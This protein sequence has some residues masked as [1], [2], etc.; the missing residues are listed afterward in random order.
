MT[1]E[2]ASHR[3]DEL[4]LP[5]N[6]RPLGENAC[7][8]HSVFHRL[9]MHLAPRSPSSL[10]SVRA[11][12]GAAVFSAT[13]P[14]TAPGCPKSSNPSPTAEIRRE[15]NSSLHKIWALDREFDDLQRSG[16]FN[17]FIDPCSGNSQATVILQKH[18]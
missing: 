17:G 7:L 5:H 3:K 4:L 15:N 9:A 12:Q 13:L 2:G 11:G 6:H 18:P 14:S 10:S 1:T 8:R 16:H